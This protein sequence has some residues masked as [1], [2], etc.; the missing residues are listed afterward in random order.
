MQIE[1]VDIDETRVVHV[2]QSCAVILAVHTHHSYAEI[3]N[4]LRGMKPLCSQ[5]DSWPGSPLPSEGTRGQEGG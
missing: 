1:R 4:C 3:K 5:C 2:C